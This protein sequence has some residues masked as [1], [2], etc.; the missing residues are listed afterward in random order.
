MKNGTTMNKSIIPKFY[1]VLYFFAP[2]TMRIIIRKNWISL[3]NKKKYVI[4]VKTYFTD[5]KYVFEKLLCG[6]FF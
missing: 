3:N 2:M 5:E 4:R 1:L 6:Y